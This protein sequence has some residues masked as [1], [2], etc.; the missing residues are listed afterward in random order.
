MCGECW[1]LLEM[2]LYQVKGKVFR[3]EACFSGIM[4]YFY[5][6]TLFRHGAWLLLCRT[7]HFSSLGLASVP[8]T[9]FSVFRAVILYGRSSLA[10]MMSEFSP[11]VSLGLVFFL[12]RS[13]FRA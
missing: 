12:S 13:A 1:V 4:R 2:I 11:R 9:R 3:A 6:P 10:V 7:P 8:A 5:L